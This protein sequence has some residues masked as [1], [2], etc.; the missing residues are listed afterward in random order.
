M[1]RDEI[2]SALRKAFSVVRFERLTSVSD[3]EAMVISEIRDSYDRDDEDYDDYGD[4][5]TE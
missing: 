3:I 2:I 5:E 4:D 1:S